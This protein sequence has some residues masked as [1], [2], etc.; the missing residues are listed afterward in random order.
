[1][2]TYKVPFSYTVYGT[3]V[4]IEAETPEEAQKWLFD[5][6]AQNGIDEFEYTAN[7]RE[8][9]TQEAKEATK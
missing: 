5:E 9:L 2:K 8:Y 3:A 4:N 7:D 1:M 6:L